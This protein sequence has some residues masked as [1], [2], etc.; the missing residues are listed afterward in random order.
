MGGAACKE[1]INVS[2]R[3]DGIL[4]VFKEEVPEVSVAILRSLVREA[5]QSIMYS[6]LYLMVEDEGEIPET[7]TT[8]IRDSLK[9]IVKELPTKNIEEAKEF[10][11]KQTMKLIQSLDKLE[12][13]F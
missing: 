8:P 11:A 9:K 1:I 2:N 12:E 6:S 4:T 10:I 7:Y 5:G 13:L 3:A